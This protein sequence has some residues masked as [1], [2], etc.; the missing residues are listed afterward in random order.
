MDHL[1][2]KAIIASGFHTAKRGDIDCFQNA[3]ISIGHDGAMLSVLR[4]HD[5]NYD[6]QKDRQKAA[7]L[8]VTL[9]E[10]FYLLPGFVDLHI[11]APQ[12]P[13]LGSALDVPLEV[14]L[15]KYTFP[16][17]ARYADAAALEDRK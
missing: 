17:E 11:H 9:P 10:G 1:R 7:G 16:L 4:P 8:L 15:Q 5:D 14:W 12:Y 2:G 6:E 13:Q 3:L